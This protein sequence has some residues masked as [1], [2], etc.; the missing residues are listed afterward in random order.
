[1]KSRREFVRSTLP[2]TLGLI[3]SSRALAA[4]PQ[5]LSEDDPIAVALGYRHD[6]AAVDPA[7]HPN[8]AP[9]RL[10]SG[11]QLYQAAASEPWAGCAAIPGKLVAAGGWCTAW[12]KK[13]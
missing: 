6:A 4:E 13:A 11:C 10:C 1:M 9:G 3:A 12:A 8:F 2:L 5:R 7:R